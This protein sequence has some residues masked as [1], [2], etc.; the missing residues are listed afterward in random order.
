MFLRFEPSQLWFLQSDGFNIKLNR[1]SVNFYQ[2]ILQIVSNGCEFLFLHTDSQDIEVA[3][4]FN[5]VPRQQK[6]MLEFLLSF[7]FDLTLVLAAQM[8]FA[9]NA[10]Y[11]QVCY[12]LPIEAVGQQ[13]RLVFLNLRF[14][15]RQIR[16]HHFVLNVDVKNYLQ[17]EKS[18]VLVSNLL[19]FKHAIRA[20]DFGSTVLT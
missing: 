18:I 9:V 2:S 19:V 8:R 11:F 13:W 17:Y 5:H 15:L 6:W 10:K 4:L 3:F 16:G 14:L 20:R 7:A 12:F 1:S